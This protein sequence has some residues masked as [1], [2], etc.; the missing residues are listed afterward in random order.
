MIRSL[1]AVAVAALWLSGSATASEAASL[2]FRDR[3]ALE[4]SGDE[5]VAVSIVHDLSDVD[6]LVAALNP[7]SYVRLDAFRTLLVRVPAAR[8]LDAANRPDVATVEIIADEMTSRLA[9]I[10]SA[11]QTVST[12]HGRLYEFGVLNVSLGVPKHLLGADRSGERTVRGALRHLAQD[13]GIPVIMSIGNNGPLADT[14]NPWS[15]ADGVM[16]A[17]ATDVSGTVLWEGSS[18][19]SADRAAGH[20]VFAAHGY[21]S[22]GARAAG[23]PK[24]PA[25]LE[26]EK[27]VDLT[28]LVGKGN[29]QHYRVDSGTSYAAAE[30][31]RALCTV[32][33]AVQALRFRMNALLPLTATLPPFVRAYIDTGLDTTHPMFASRI[34]NRPP[35]YAGLTMTVTADERQLLQALVH[36]GVALDIRY[37]RMIALAALKRAAVPVPGT[38]PAETGHGFVSRDRVASSVANWTAKTLVELFAADSHPGAEQWL[39]RVEQATEPVFSPDETARFA[40]YC[41]DYDLMMMFDVE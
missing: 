33:Q 38:G 19:Y 5:P 25:M 20:D 14:V 26:A 30:I 13:R 28:A 22:V 36:A 6:G 35:I 16:A 2:Q 21:L 17:T 8:L 18:R 23:S 37:D 4:Q 29:E 40:A 11:M 10:L 9:G 24:T 7:G 15:M 3:L 34:A 31:T 27:L 32:H 39:K 41:A 12:L 1:G